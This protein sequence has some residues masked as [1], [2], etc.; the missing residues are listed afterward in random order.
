MTK[1]NDSFPIDERRECSPGHNGRDFE[2]RERRICRGKERV[3][4]LERSPDG[5]PE[6]S[7]LTDSACKSTDEAEIE[8]SDLPTSHDVDRRTNSQTRRIFTPNT[9]L[10]FVSLPICSPVV[11]VPR[12]TERKKRLEDR[13]G[14]VLREHWLLRLATVSKWSTSDSCPLPLVLCGA[15]EV[16]VRSS[17][18]LIKDC[19]NLAVVF[20]PCGCGR[21]ACRCRRTKLGTGG[22]GRS[23]IAENFI[24]ISRIMR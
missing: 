4:M 24:G 10:R 19:S 21:F 3:E 23:P 7:S 13:S 5:A 20:I 22:S 2:D 1:T 9:T 14:D 17:S 8:T 6:T 18:C 11:S 16:F 12:T 15:A